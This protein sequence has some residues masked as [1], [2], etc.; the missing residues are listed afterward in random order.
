MHSLTLCMMGAP[1]NLSL[2]SAESA[3]QA[4]QLKATSEIGAVELAMGPNRFISR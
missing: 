2:H 1:L 4:P 3:G